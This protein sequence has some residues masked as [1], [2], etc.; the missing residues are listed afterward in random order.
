MKICKVFAEHWRWR[1]PGTGAVLWL[2]CFPL[3]CP[4]KPF[5][6]ALELDTTKFVL[7]CQSCHLSDFHNLSD[8][9]CC[10]YLIRHL[11]FH[12]LTLQIGR[13]VQ[14]QKSG[15]RPTRNHA[16]M[17]F[18]FYTCVQSMSVFTTCQFGCL[19][20]NCICY[21]S[22]WKAATKVVDLLFGLTFLLYDSISL[23]C[24]FPILVTEKLLLILWDNLSWILLYHCHPP[25]KITQRF[26]LLFELKK[27]LKWG[28][29]SFPTLNF[30][31]SL[32]TTI[33]VKFFEK[34]LWKWGSPI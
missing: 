27:F 12:P 23:N 21:A 3:F 25:R 4:S 2:L 15:P 34:I 31:I 5:C 18:I 19:H 33:L 28:G 24:N 6:S 17:L 7:C 13:V 1:P 9:L 29:E 30:F 14:M 32:E 16:A 11:N 22:S 8:M 20:F 26:W 10:W